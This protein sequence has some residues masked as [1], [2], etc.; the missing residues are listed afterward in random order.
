M[1]DFT[2]PAPAPPT[3]PLP[4]PTVFPPPQPPVAQAITFDQE[5]RIRALEGRPPLTLLE[6]TALMS[7]AT[8]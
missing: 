5:N 7:Q 3:E 6:F 2:G 8:P 1:A 4:N